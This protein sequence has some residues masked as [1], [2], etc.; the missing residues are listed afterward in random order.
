[1][2]RYVSSQP[3]TGVLPDWFSAL[4]NRPVF[5]VPADRSGFRQSVAYTSPDASSGCKLEVSVCDGPGRR[6]PTSGRGIGSTM[7]SF[8]KPPLALWWLTLLGA[9]YF[10]AGKFGLSLAI[11][12][13]SATPV[14]PPTGIALAAFLLFGSRVWPAVLVGAFLVNITTT[15]SIATSIGIAVGNTLE[16][17]LGADL[18]SLFA[19][20]RGA[21][22]RAR[23]VFKFFVLAGFFA[24]TVSATI[25]V[26]SLTLAGYASWIDYGPI[27]FTWW[28]GDAV[29]ALVVGPI[30]ILWSAPS[31]VPWTRARML[32][33]AGLLAAMIA[34]GV[35]VFSG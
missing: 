5:P 35:L 22:D 17:R 31:T 34:L 6:G 19:N 21:F 16:G 4:R 2:P 24:T 1:M 29:G 7:T 18:V 32:E 11:V 25:G 14:W 12:N 15:G 20:G 3:L 10:V 9:A 30:V 23:D 13:A 8:R 28:L 27:W 33:A 26:T